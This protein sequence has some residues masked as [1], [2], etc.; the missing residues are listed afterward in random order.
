MEEY[1]K[2]KTVNTEIQSSQLF[3]D[4]K[5]GDIKAFSGLYDTHV[6]LLYNYGIRLTTDKE[7]LKDCIQEV[8]VK[9]YNK[10]NELDAVQNIKSYLIISLKNKLCDESRKRIH[11]SD[12]AVDEID[13]TSGESVENS[14]IATEKEQT[15]CA[16]LAKM[17]SKLSFRQRKAI[18]LYYFEER[19]Y[20]DI[21]EIMEMNYQSVRNLIHR[22]MVKLRS[23][24][25]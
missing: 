24:A 17:M 4:F 3:E 18:E 6:N 23:C 16:F 21:C 13:I 10:R 25:C 15:D 20:E 1:Y 8:F 11:L 12:I 14:Y 19:K 2:S 9:I 7:L 22:G 5:K